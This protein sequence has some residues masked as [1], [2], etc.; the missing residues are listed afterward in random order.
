MQRKIKGALF[1][2]KGW[3]IVSAF[4]TQVATHAAQWVEVLAEASGINLH[5]PA[6]FFNSTIIV[7]KKER[8][9]FCPFSP[10]TA[11]SMHCLS[12]IYDI[13]PAP[14]GKVECRSADLRFKSAV[15]T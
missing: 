1:Q 13:K 5:Q 11:L 12:A 3:F 9:S 15:E 7:K 2:P 4:L 8:A 6:F 10:F 14:C